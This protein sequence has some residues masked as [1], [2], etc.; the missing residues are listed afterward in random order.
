MRPVCW[1]PPTA[2]DGIRDGPRPPGYRSR[3]APTGET[4]RS[5]RWRCP[6]GC[7]ACLPPSSSSAQEEWSVRALVVEQGW[8]R[9]GLA[10]GRAL[11]SAGW[12]VG[13]AAPDSRGLA[14]WSRRCHRTHRVPPLHRSVDAFVEGVA[15]AV[16]VGGYDVVFGSGEAEVLALS[17]ARDALGARF[18][19][20]P[21]TSVL[22]ALDKGELSA[23]ATAV[24]I[25]LPE[26]GPVEAG[27]GEGAP[28]GGQ[29]PP[30]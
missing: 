8:S 25:A 5:Q 18:P 27:A 10:A 29:G 30:A 12:A 19:H 20:G 26:G 13:V 9:G 28:R 24:G 14:L 21:H 11:A 3:A 7:V 1:P 16:R 2:H 4:G 6:T 17:A 23:D 22:R 15:R